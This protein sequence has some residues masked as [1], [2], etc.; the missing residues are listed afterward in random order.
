[1]LQ[2][3]RV[4]CFTVSALLRENE[5]RVRGEVKLLPTPSRLRLKCVFKAILVYSSLTYI[6]H[7][8]CS[9][10]KNV[11]CKQTRDYFLVYH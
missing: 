9:T 1:M 11:C 5:Q 8:K 4:T 2:N 10:A 7:L 3:A 6:V